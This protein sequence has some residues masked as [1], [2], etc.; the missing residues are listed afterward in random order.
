MK[1]GGSAG[2]FYKYVW[3]ENTA[4][5]V[6]MMFRYRTSKIKKQ[7]TG[8]SADYRYYGIELP[9]YSIKQFEIKKDLIYAG[10]GSF[11]S[12][13]LFSRYKF[14][15]RSIN[16]YQIEQTNNKSMMYHWDLGMAFI[17]GYELEGNLQFNFQLGFRNMFDESF[18]NFWMSSNL[19]GLGVGYRF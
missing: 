18:G 6:D 10:I 12:F 8:E 11:A 9:V 7:T 13:G 19:I 4:F 1:A 16:P 15:D 2:F 17:I 5:E 3:F 14:S